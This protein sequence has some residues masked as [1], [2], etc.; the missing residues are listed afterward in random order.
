MTSPSAPSLVLASSSP[1]RKILLE[2]LRQPFICSSPDI[3][4][5]HLA[6]ESPASYVKRLA[7]NKAQALAKQFPNHLIIGSD[8]CAVIDGQI[9]G[10]PHTQEKAQQ[11]LTQA[12]GQCIT[13]FTG[14]CCYHSDSQRLLST[15]DRYHV[16]FRQLSSETIKRYIEVE[17]PLDCAGS[18]KSEGLGIRL[19]ERLEGKD[20]NT[21]VGLPLIDLVDML[22]QFG[23]E[24]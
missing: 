2:K 4:E 11:Q 16:H 24:V 13:F 7:I 6:G 22:E 23:I 15:V 5:S 14:L 10:K 1:Y 19:F 20:P 8:Q 18:F 9:I 3:D 12:S 17:Q 21:L